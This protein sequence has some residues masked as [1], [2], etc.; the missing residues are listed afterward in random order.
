[1]DGGDF[2]DRRIVAKTEGDAIPESLA[3]QI[4][5]VFVG[6]THTPQRDLTR[7]QSLIDQMIGDPSARGLIVLER[8]MT[9]MTQGFGSTVA[10][11]TNLTDS[12]AQPNLGFGLTAKKRSLVVAG[13]VFLCV[14]GGNQ[15]AHDRVLLLCGENH[16]DIVKGFE[17]FVTHTTLTWMAKRPRSHHII[18][19]QEK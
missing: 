4:T 18:D 5:T 15:I 13:Y 10:L 19:S 16:S 12:S 1:M 2:L 7:G 8:G 3:G 11:E 17:Y 14:A 6:E 9:Y